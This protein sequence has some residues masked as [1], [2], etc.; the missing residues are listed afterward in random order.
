MKFLHIY[1]IP[2]HLE[3]FLFNRSLIGHSSAKSEKKNQ[4]VCF[5]MTISWPLPSGIQHKCSHL[6]LHGSCIVLGRYFIIV[7]QAYTSSMSGFVC[8]DSSCESVSHPL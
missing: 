7:G 4:S 5:I 8:Y 1:T 2:I 6:R 3:A